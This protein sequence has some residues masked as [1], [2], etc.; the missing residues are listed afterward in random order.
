MSRI[1][2]QPVIIPDKVKVT[3]TGDTVHVEGP[4]RQSLQALR[5]RREDHHR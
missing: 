5:A 1:G 2:K 3:L 4:Q